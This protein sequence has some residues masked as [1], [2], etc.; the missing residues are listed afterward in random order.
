MGEPALPVLLLDIDNTVVDRDGAFLRLFRDLLERLLPGSPADREAALRRI[1][2]LDGSG[3]TDRARFCAAVVREFPSLGTD[4]QELWRRHRRLPDFVMVDEEVVA[5]LGR[6]SLRCRLVAA[7]NGSGEMQRG[8]LERAG[9][10]RFFTR[11]LVSGEMGCEKPQAAFFEQV[12]REFPEAF[13]MVGD[14][15]DNDILPARNLGL[16]TVLIRRDAGA[17]RVACDR[18]IGSVLELEEALSCLT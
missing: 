9:I 5:L 11:V 15:P 1:L 18:E 3:R 6:L 12:L 7:S 14:D 13:A 10:A 4:A 17:G 16:R 2:E 8:K